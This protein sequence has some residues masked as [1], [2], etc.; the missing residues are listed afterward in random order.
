MT[1]AILLTL[2]LVAGREYLQ[3]FAPLGYM[4]SDEIVLVSMHKARYESNKIPPALRH[5]SRDWLV[6]HGWTR[7]YGQPWPARGELPS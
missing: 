5:E 2:D 4:L 3:H 7:Q 6:T 1:P